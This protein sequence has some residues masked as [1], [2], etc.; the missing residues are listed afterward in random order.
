[1]KNKWA[2][3]LFILDMSRLPISVRQTDELFK[4]IDNQTNIWYIISKTIKNAKNIY[5]PFETFEELYEAYGKVVKERN[6][7]QQKQMGGNQF[8]LN[9][10]MIIVGHIPT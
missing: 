10:L 7:D 9:F 4:K 1:M 2:K 3:F 5:A 6:I 8:M